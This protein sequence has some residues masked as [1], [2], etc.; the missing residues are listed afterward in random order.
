MQTIIEGILLGLTLSIF[1]G[2]GPALV[3]EIQTSILRGFWAAVLLAFGVFLSDAVLVA[4]GF[5]GAVQIFES[6]K[7]ILGLVGGI[8]LIIFGIV[9][10]RRPVL[11]NV[12][13][14][15]PEYK[16]QEPF[17]T[18]Y[19]LKGFFINFTNPFIWIFWMGIVVGFTANYK[20]DMLMLVSFFASALGTVLLFDVLKI[21]SAYK[22]KKYLQTHNIVW[23]N[24]IA[25]VGLV[26]FGIYLVVK[27]YLLIGV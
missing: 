9:T 24:R 6:N 4:L 12:D 8:V 25:G 20:A 18:T 21:F 17:F 2:F 3:A 5:L 10:Y 22:V 1:F 11:I 15:D 13:T 23:I 19:I 14:S 27:T 7:T 26:L 16:K